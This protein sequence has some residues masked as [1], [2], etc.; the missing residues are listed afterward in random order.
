M[1][2]LDIKLYDFAFLHFAEYI[3]TSIRL[4][5][6]LAHQD[7]EFVLRHPHDVILTAIEYV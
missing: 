6:Y 5:R 7:S 3:D 4:F 1:V 2:K